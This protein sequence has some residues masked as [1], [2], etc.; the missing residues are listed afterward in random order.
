LFY[1]APEYFHGSLV[2]K[3]IVQASRVFHIHQW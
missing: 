2:S 3:K 1:R